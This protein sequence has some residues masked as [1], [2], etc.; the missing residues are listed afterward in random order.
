[1]ST[2]KVDTSTSNE[3]KF[4][5]TFG[6]IIR[7]DIVC[8][9]DDT[10]HLVVDLNLKN[11][12]TTHNSNGITGVVVGVSD[13]FKP[14]HVGGYTPSIGDR[15]L[16]IINKTYPIRDTDNKKLLVV[17]EPDILAVLPPDA[18]ISL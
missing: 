3:C 8:N 5:P 15:I 9:E 12:Y 4:K 10:T 11:A 14:E 18:K 7:P 2:Y 16:T 13:S 1:M 6:V 17:R